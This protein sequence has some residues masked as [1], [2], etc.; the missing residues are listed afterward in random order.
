MHLECKTAIEGN[1]NTVHFLTF[2]IEETF[3]S[4]CQAHEINFQVF[5]QNNNKDFH[6]ENISGNKT[7]MFMGSKDK[8][9]D[10]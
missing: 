4:P 6:M 10:Y 2:S 5:D 9:F 7:H 1:E 3:V 8:S